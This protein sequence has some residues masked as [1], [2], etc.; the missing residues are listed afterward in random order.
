MMHN[1]D[2]TLL[3]GH[4][5]VREVEVRFQHGMPI[6][7]LFFTVLAPCVLLIHPNTSRTRTDQCVDRSEIED[8]I[9]LDLPRQRT[10]CRA[11]LKYTNKQAVFETLHD[12]WLTGVRVIMHWECVEIDPLASPLLVEVAG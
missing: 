7:D 4:D 8:V 10:R 3:E 9:G 11:E 2:Q 5:P 6:S 1:L 12:L